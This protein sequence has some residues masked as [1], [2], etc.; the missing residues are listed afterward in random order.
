MP[1][2]F[3]LA[4]PGGAA[5]IFIWGPSGNG[6]TYTGLAMA[7]VLAGDRRVAVIDTEGGKSQKYAHRWDFDISMPKDHSPTTYIHLMDEVEASP[8]YGALLI[9]SFT[10]AWMGKNG[11]LDIHD[12]Q[13][14]LSRS[15]SFNA[16]IV[17]T[18][19]QRRI[20]ERILAFTK[21]LICTSRA[22]ERWG[23]DEI[24]GRPKDLGERP[25]QGK[26]IWYEFDICGYLDKNHT[27]Q[28]D[29]SDCSALD[30]GEIPLP[31]EELA[32]QVLRWLETGDGLSDAD[33]LRRRVRDMARA[34][35]VE[36]W[37]EIVDSLGGDI[38][39][40]QGYLEG[41]GG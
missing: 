40:L 9:D 2:S 7:S 26:G 23:V 21:H 6:K 32:R 38:E 5:K 22:H 12:R 15:N 10:H 4:T 39:A 30:G 11:I 24:T 34:M 41:L 27:L 29:K 18:P 20:T 37:Q 3:H 17:A 28:I 36:D 25:F 33:I 1:G 8:V 35:R 31:G 19:E 13:A 16:W 14:S